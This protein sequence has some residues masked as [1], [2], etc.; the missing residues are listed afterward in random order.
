M[1]NGMRNYILHNSLDHKPTNSGLAP[2]LSYSCILQKCN[3]CLNANSRFIHSFA[4]SLILRSGGYLNHT[5]WKST[6]VNQ[7]SKLK[8]MPGISIDC[9]AILRSSS[10]IAATTEKVCT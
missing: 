9:D 5:C 4:S 8:T 10:P 7:T 6:D 2:L 1:P 3:I